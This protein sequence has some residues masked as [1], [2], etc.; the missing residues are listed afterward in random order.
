[1]INNAKELIIE[2]GIKSIDGNV[3]KEFKELETI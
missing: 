2:E 1:M 3:F